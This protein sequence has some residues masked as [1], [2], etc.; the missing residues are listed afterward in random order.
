MRLSKT[1]FA[2]LVLLIAMAPSASGIPILYGFENGLMVVVGDITYTYDPPSVFSGTPDPLAPALFLFSP[3][4]GE[5]IASDPDA[6]SPPFS[7]S[8]SGSFKWDPYIEYTYTATNDSDQPL[9]F[10]WTSV[11]DL[12]G[13]PFTHGL[14]RLSGTLTD[15]NGGGVTAT[16]TGSYLQFTRLD[17]LDQGLD[18]GDAACSGDGLC[19][20]TN[21]NTV[22]SP[23]IRPVQML[24]NLEFTL[25]PGDQAVFEG[26]SGV[27]GDESEAPEPAT[28]FLAGAGLL[29]LGLLGRR[30]C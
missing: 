4:T 8:V 16:P 24:L 1:G 17:G 5:W 27:F 22:Y 29:A 9:T 13:G 25:T 20:F 2:V 10:T 11:M 6:P 30:R 28:Y 18:I 23:S 21:V 7:F 12:A 26:Y 19:A 14:S 3:A 15:R